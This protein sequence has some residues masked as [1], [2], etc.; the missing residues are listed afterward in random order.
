VLKI[1]EEH[2]YRIWRALGL[3]LQGVSEAGLGHPEAG[4]A[5]TE[6]GIALY[7]NLRTPPVFWPNLLGLRAET[8][9]LAGRSAEAI[10]LFDQ[11]ITLAGR[12]R[13]TTVGLLV[14]KGD[15]LLSLGDG[16]G[17]ES[18]LRRAFDEAGRAGARM[19]Q[20]RAAT[21]L[22]RLAAPARRSSATAVLREVFETFTEGFDTLDLL[23]ARAVL[24]KAATVARP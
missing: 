4:L 23:E 13:L 8:C 2:D 19:I 14:Q 17:A 24:A 1:A 11:A 12:D 3:V 20:L 16:E 15:L 7:E 9:G 22:A 5:R 6:Q 21:R 10:D 18:W